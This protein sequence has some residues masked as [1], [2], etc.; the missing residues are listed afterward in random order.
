MPDSKFKKWFKTIIGSLLI[1]ASLVEILYFEIEQQTFW[2]TFGI[3][4]LFVFMDYKDIKEI[5]RNKLK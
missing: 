5:I 2:I 4:C 1:V 3:G